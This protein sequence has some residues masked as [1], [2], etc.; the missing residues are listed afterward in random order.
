MVF[1]L[2]IASR[3]GKVHTH[4]VLLFSEACAFCKQAQLLTYTERMCVCLGV[5]V[6]VCVCLHVKGRD[7]H[8]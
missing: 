7:K 8:L 4:S 5:C 6:G 1:E 3:A 2:W